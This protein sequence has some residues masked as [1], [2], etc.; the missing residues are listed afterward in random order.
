MNFSTFRK[1]SES[2]GDLNKIILHGLGEP[3]VHESFVD[4]VKL[5]REQLGDEGEIDFST[6]GSMLTGDLA[7]KL[8]RNIG[9]NKILFS[10]DTLEHSFLEKFRVGAVGNNII[11][12][13]VNI[14]KIKSKSKLP[15]S[16]SIEVTL[17]KDNYKDLPNLIEFAVENGIDDVLVTNLIVYSQ[18]LNGQQLYIPSSRKSYEIVG[19]VLDK[20]WEIIHAAIVGAY[21]LTHTGKYEQ[22][23]L[24]RYR[25]LW[26]KAE[27]EGYWIN[28][29]LLLK[30]RDQLDRTKEVEDVF[31]KS[32]RIARKGGVNLEFPS[33]FADR[34]SRVCPY[35]KNEVMVVRA[36]G[37]AVPCLEYMYPHT[38][39][40]NH[41]AKDIGMMAFGNVKGQSVKDIWNSDEYAGFRES[42]KSIDE[43][44]P[45][46]G[47]CVYSTL[48]CFYIRSNEIDCQRIEGSCCE[49]L[50]STNIVK[51]ML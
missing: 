47:D 36:D 34:K 17:M 50:Y 14:S 22:A 4:I 51:C 37:S 9:V 24:E 45:W 29:P 38:E 40:V 12:N 46:C 6:N 49:C 39:Y 44:I 15:F 33:I 1:L 8:I 25:N 5:T 11:E 23:D 16:L 13:L 2:F 7:N 3:L 26:E 28:L 21:G 19:N 43:K 41:H 27:N 10:L 20:G 48:D 35:I 32:S 42:R 30:M 18:I 31:E